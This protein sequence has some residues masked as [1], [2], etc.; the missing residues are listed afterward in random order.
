MTSEA[1]F[2]D[3]DVTARGLHVDL[4]ADAVD[5]HVPRSADDTRTDTVLGTDTRYCTSQ[6]NDGPTQS[7]FTTSDPPSTPTLMSGLKSVHFA[8]RLTCTWL[9]SAGTTMTSPAELSMTTSVGDPWKDTTSFSCRRR[10]RN[11]ARITARIASTAA[12]VTGQRD[13]ALWT[14]RFRASAF[15]SAFLTAVLTT[16]W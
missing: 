9:P 8:R 7:A 4:A 1:R 13:A 5:L 15:L 12:T 3:R 11:T 10:T 16:P 2:V 14:S 6:M